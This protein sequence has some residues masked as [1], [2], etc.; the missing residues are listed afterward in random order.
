MRRPSDIPKPSENIIFSEY[1]MDLQKKELERFSFEKE[2]VIKS[3]I[4]TERQTRK[5]RL[6]AVMVAVIVML[7]AGYL[8][9]VIIQKVF[10]S[11]HSLDGISMIWAVSPIVSI[12]VITVALLVG[13]FGKSREANSASVASTL[14]RI[15]GGSGGG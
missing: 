12:T 4:Q 2:T 11:Y 5:I 1:E 8:E 3:Q 13:A 7:F 10:H 9:W 14:A 15:A 6:F